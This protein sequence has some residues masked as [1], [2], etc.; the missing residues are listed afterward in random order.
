MF[1]FFAG[2][3]IYF[4]PETQRDGVV[5]NPQL[6]LVNFTIEA[7]SARDGIHWAY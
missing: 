5:I 7:N 1:V 4:E 6:S 2:G 3:G